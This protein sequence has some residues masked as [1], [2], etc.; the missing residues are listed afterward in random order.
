MVIF[1]KHQNNV[2]MIIR[3]RT[4]QIS[5]IGHSFISGFPGK[6]VQK[7]RSLSLP[8]ENTKRRG[9]MNSDYSPYSNPLEIMWRAKLGKGDFPLA[10]KVEEAFECTIKKKNC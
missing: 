2:E 8:S 6:E 5:V 1:L 4:S 3:K 9:E 7:V 10:Q